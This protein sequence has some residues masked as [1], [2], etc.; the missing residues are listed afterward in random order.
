[1]PIFSQELILTLSSILFW[2]IW[3]VLNSFIV[4]LMSMLVYRS[5]F[6]F[7]KG[8]IIVVMLFIFHL[9]LAYSLGNVL[10]L[11]LLGKPKVIIQQPTQ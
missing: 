10:N 7:K 5:S 6:D 3:I 1:M 11:S 8:L 9:L 4:S 2:L